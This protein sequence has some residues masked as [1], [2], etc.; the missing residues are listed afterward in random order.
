MLNY[1]NNRKTTLKIQFL[2]NNKFLITKLRV[3]T[4]MKS[5]YKKR[6]FIHIIKITSW[7]LIEKK[8]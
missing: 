2:L 8:K 1:I 7:T 3:V 4:T 5:R 6:E